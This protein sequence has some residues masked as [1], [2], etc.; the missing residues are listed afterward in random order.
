MAS[1]LDY[2]T[3]SFEIAPFFIYEPSVLLASVKRQHVFPYIGLLGVHRL[4]APVPLVGFYQNNARVTR[5]YFYRAASQVDGID[6][7]SAVRFLVVVQITRICEFEVP[8]V[9][10]WSLMFSSAEFFQ[11][12]LLCWLG[13]RPDWRRL[14]W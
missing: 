10:L 1:V 4:Q 6:W 5:V 14:L 9:P 13:T 2:I 8:A 12:A 3:V 11:K 7:F